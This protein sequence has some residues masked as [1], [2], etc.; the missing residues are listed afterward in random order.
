MGYI[1]PLTLTI[2]LVCSPISLIICYPIVWYTVAQCFS[3]G[4]PRNLRV[5]PVVSKCS[6][7]LPVLSK[8]IKLHP[9]LWPVDAF[10]RVLVG[11][12]CI[13]GQGSAGGA[14]QHFPGYLVVG[15]ELAAP[16]CKNDSPDVGIFWPQESPAKKT[17][18]PWAIKI[19]AKGSASLK[20]LKN[21]AVA[22]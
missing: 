4:V 11:P 6:M 22:H 8:R 2:T 21:T 5:P 13:C 14:L 12:K 20:R 10:S 19:A 7:G 17:W 15:R 18:V 1:G 3:T 16:L 9:N